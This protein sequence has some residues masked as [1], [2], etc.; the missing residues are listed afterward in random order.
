MASI[1][2]LSILAS[3][4]S[5]TPLNC[6]LD[7]IFTSFYFQVLIPESKVSIPQEKLLTIIN[8]KFGIFNLSVIAKFEDFHLH[9]LEKFH[10]VE[11][12]RVGDSVNIVEL[13]SF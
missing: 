8:I 9:A 6:F 12:I 11:D 7:S 5:V 2:S 10:M 1:N 4:L 3:Y 13:F